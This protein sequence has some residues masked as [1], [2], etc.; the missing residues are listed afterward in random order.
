MWKEPR[1]TPGWRR[2]AH[3]NRH[4]PKAQKLAKK[5]AVDLSTVAATGRFGRVTEDDVKRALGTLTEALG[6]QQGA[7]RSTSTLN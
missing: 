2:P 4:A 1:A 7:R 6:I 3:D 5:E